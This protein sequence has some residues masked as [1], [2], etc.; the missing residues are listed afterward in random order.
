MASRP[1]LPSLL[2]GED[3]VGNGVA[4]FTIHVYSLG[5]RLLHVP[6]KM[7]C[8]SLSAAIYSTRIRGNV[9]ESRQVMPATTPAPGP[10]GTMFEHR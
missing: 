8:A 5:A 2:I 10:L 3:T 4:S 1:A 9:H 6:D 7:R